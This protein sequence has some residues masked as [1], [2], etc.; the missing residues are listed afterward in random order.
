MRAVNCGPAVWRST[1]RQASTPLRRNP[2]P[3]PAGDAKAN[4][5][6]APRRKLGARSFLALGPDGCCEPLLL[7]LRS[8]GDRANIF[9]SI[10]TKNYCVSVSSPRNAC[11]SCHPHLPWLSRSPDKHRRGGLQLRALLRRECQ[12]D[13]CRELA[14]LVLPQERRLALREGAASPSAWSRRWTSYLLWTSPS[15]SPP[16]CPRMGP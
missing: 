1:V 7:G 12:F 14:A 2:S 6:G 13:L 10:S 3:A 8:G 9:W 15:P 4:E 5:H 11:Y 16:A